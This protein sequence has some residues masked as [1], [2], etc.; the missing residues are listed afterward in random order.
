MT[1]KKVFFGP[2]KTFSLSLSLSTTFYEFLLLK[3]ASTCRLEAD[4]A[5][6]EDA[7]SLDAVHCQCPR[8]LN[9]L[10]IALL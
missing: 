7:V 8:L 1:R 6:L 10:P 5:F 3:L 9:A 2:D 4:N